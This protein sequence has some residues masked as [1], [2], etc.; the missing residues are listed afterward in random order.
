[1]LR[2]VHNFYENLDISSPQSEFYRTNVLEKMENASTES[3]N[4]LN[5][6]RSY[7]KLRQPQICQAHIFFQE[8]NRI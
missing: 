3:V 5:I 8:A 4:S 2:F 1:M 7:I 6:C